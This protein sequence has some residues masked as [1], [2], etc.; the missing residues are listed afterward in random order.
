MRFTVPKFIEHEAK[1][2]GPLT[3]KQ[4]AFIGTAAF[5]G[6]I[7]YFTVSFSIFII[8]CLVLGGGAMALAFLKI[9]GKPLPAFLGNLLLFRLS[10]KIYV[11]RKIKSRLKIFKKAKFEKQET[12]EALSLKITQKGQLKNLKTKVDTTNK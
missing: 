2:V 5:I 9:E 12:D 3:F 7:L 4:F 10:P 6:F 1:I 8:A 11:W